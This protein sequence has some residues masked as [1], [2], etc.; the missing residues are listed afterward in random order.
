MFFDRSG[1]AKRRRELKNE[2]KELQKA[3]AAAGCD[4]AEA[5]GRCR[6]LG[7]TIELGEALC[8][9]YLSAR[10][11]L[12]RAREAIPKLLDCMGESPADEVEKSLQSLMTDLEQVYHD[13]SIREDDADF[14]STVHSLK[15]LAGQYAGSVAQAKTEAGRAFPGIMLRSE[16]ENVGAVLDDAAAWNAPDFLALAYFFRHEDRASLKE[17]ENE[18]R[19]HYVSGY[20]SEHFEEPF[21]AME[22]RA[23]RAGAL[24]TLSEKYFAKEHMS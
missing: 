11:H 3:F 20:W 13:C 21:A 10:A 8:D 14:A 18:Q 17:M 19:N 9:G 6:E 16:L 23:D 22:Q 2:L 5:A 24:R 12:A 7:E 1:K 15:K 4:K